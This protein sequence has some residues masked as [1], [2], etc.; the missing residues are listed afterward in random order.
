MRAFHV[1]LIQVFKGYQHQNGVFHETFH[2][3]DAKPKEIPVDFQHFHFLYFQWF[4]FQ[5]SH[6]IVAHIL[7]DLLILGS[8]ALIGVFLRTIFVVDFMDPIF[9]SAFFWVILRFAFSGLQ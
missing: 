2:L 9:I 5:E 7:I 8:L 3:F 4:S 1:G 6:E